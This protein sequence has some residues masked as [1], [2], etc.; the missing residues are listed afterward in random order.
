MFWAAVVAEVSGQLG[1]SLVKF[2][3][4]DMGPEGVLPD[5]QLLDP[6]LKEASTAPLAQPPGKGMDGES[7]WDPPCRCPPSPLAPLTPASGP[8]HPHLS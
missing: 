4:G 6:L 2:C 3:S 8:Q 1:K 5:T 7:R